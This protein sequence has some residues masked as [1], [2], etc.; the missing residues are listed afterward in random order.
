MKKF[1]FLL[2]SLTCLSYS[3]TSDKTEQTIESNADEG[4]VCTFDLINDQING[5]PKPGT[6]IINYPR[7]KIGDT[8]K[9]KFLDGTSTEHEIVKKYASEWTKYANLK[10]DFVSKEE[11][12]HLR[13]VFN[14]D[15]RGGGA[16][17]DL[18]AQLLLPRSIYKDYQDTPS[19]R[20]GPIDDSE[21]SRRTILHEFGHALGLKHEMTNPKSPIKWNL[22]KV[23]AYY[24][25]LMGLSK[26]KVDKDIINK[27]IVNDYSEYDP[28]SIMHYYVPAALT[29]DGVTVARQSVLSDIDKLSIHKW[30]PFKSAIGAGQITYTALKEIRSPNGRYS[31]T[32]SPIGTLFVTDII[33]NRIH[34]QIFTVNPN[35]YTNMSYFLLPN[36]NFVIKGQKR[37]ELT[38]NI[39]WSTETAG[40]P[41][42]VLSLQDNGH[43]LVLW[44]GY[45]VWNSKKAKRKYF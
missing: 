44:N 12:T 2:I 34:W 14:N 18:G 4:L 9:I 39:I 1:F 20:L 38:Q 22:S 24:Y 23:Y 42:A 32:F 17:S 10:F 19:M 13:I 45:A 35:F 37:G 5:A 36:G 43:L 16:W 15:D 7:W 40:Y 30:Y 29:L 3:C 33:S 31:L 11:D 25:D 27:P 8:I 21:S 28:L 41:G 6:V 26:E